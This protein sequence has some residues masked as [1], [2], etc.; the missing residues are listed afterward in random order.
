M[1][2]DA[3]IPN[4][5]SSVPFNA[6]TEPIQ[7]D[8]KPEIDAEE[9]ANMETGEV[10]E[11]RGQIRHGTIHSRHKRNEERSWNMFRCSSLQKKNP[12]YYHPHYSN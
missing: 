10:K 8:V 6:K 2:Y 5:N 4:A 7:I 3:I 12:F 9:G 1:L 11:H